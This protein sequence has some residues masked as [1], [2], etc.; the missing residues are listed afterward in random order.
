MNKA[1][2]QQCIRWNYTWNL[3]T[4]TTHETAICCKPH[5]SSN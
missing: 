2:V 5:N 4:N 1:T 3:H